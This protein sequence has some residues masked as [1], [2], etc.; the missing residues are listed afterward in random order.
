MGGEDDCS[1]TIDVVADCGGDEVAGLAVHACCGFVEE[2]KVWSAEEGGG[3]A[4]ALSLAAGESAVG[5]VGEGADVKGR[6]EFLW[7]Y[8]VAVETGELVEEVSGG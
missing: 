8:G 6:N 4:D 3:E 2:S 7:R 1:A 5:A